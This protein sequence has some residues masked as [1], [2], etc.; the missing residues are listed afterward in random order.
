MS[1]ILL[2]IFLLLVDGGVLGIVNE[3]LTLDELHLH[4]LGIGFLPGCLLCIYLVSKQIRQSDLLII[5]LSDS[6]QFSVVVNLRLYLGI[7]MHWIGVSNWQEVLG[8]Y[9]GSSLLQKSIWSC[10]T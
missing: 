4:T 7:W 3:V 10:T 2:L 1:C 8:I 9:D 6:V 5:L